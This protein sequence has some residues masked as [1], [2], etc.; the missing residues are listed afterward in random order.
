M[1]EENPYKAPE[2]E[3]VTEN[4]IDVPQKILKKIQG[5]WIA[6]IVSICITVA[7]TVA[8]LSGNDL[9]G[10]DETAFID[11]I[12]MCIF[13]YGI[14]KKSRISAVLMLL[15]FALNKAIMWSQ[16]GALNGLGVALI[17]FWFYTQGVIGTFQYH[18]FM[19]NNA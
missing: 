16:A 12:L 15:L 18:R 9:L 19:K 7:F 14:Y 1:V 13:A 5:A 8:S 11:V 4:E 10:L 6:G 2:A 17:F 3:L